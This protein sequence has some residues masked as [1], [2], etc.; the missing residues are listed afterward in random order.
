MT[1]K[2]QKATTKNFTIYFRIFYQL[3]Y[4]ANFF[5]FFLLKEAEHGYASTMP[6]KM[7]LRGVTKRPK[8]KK[9]QGNRYDGDE[10]FFIRFLFFFICVFQDFPQRT[11][12][13]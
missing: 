4:Y 7:D 9:S 5:S 6:I 11:G 8:T 12:E 2:Q 10:E 3:C 1:S 13:K